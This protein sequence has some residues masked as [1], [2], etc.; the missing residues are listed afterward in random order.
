VSLHQS[1]AEKTRSG[2]SALRG[3]VLYWGILL[4]GSIVFETLL[5]RA[6]DSIRNHLGLV[7]PWMWTPAIASMVARLALGEGLQDVSFRFGGF[8]GGR[9]A[10]LGWLFPVGV[11]GVAYGMAW[12]TG[13]A[14]FKS[15]V[16]PGAAGITEPTVAF[17]LL[18]A[19]RLTIGVPIAAL[20]AA[21]EE[22]GWRGYMLTRL[23]EARVPN[24]ILVSGL[25]WATWHLPLILGGVYASGQHSVTSAGFFSVAI[26]AQAYVFARLRL[27]S[28][29][30]WP[31]IVGHA[32]WNATIQ[33]VFDFSTVPNS[34]AIWVGESG[35]LVAVTS[36]GLAWLVVRGKRRWQRAPGVPLDVALNGTNTI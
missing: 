6:G 29:S 32:A 31:A 17:L 28:G 15:P 8:A 16:V 22:I 9:M 34:S 19:I 13:L 27:T 5:L 4:A 24:P 23:I 21:G 12:S 30:V 11:G 3:L 35:I 7:L 14:A 20:A 10:L 25:I 26:V 18:L 36:C 33:G 1:E 2:R